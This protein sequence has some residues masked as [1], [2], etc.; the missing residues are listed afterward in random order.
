MWWTL[1][2]TGCWLASEPAATNPIAPPAYTNPVP[3][4]P[5]ERDAPAH[6]DPAP[7][8]RFRVDAAAHPDAVCNDGTTPVFY[9]RPGHGEGTEK[10]IVWMK[11]GGSCFDENSC[12]RRE[13]ARRSAK[14]WMRKEK[15]VLGPDDDGE[16]DGEGRAGGILDPRAATN[17]DFHNFNHAYLVYCSSDN[18][19]G[20]R[21]ASDATWGMHFQGSRIIDAMVDALSDPDV[22]GDNPLKSAELLVLA[23]SSA[24]AIGMRNNIDRLADELGPVRVIGISD[25]GVAPKPLPEDIELN[26]ALFKQKLALWAPRL[27]TS[28][29]EAEADDSLCLWPTRT[30]QRGHVKTPILM[31]QDQFDP[32]SMRRYDPKTQR[33]LIAKLASD[34][35]EIGRSQDAAFVPATRNHILLTNEK[36]FSTE[37][38]GVSMAEVSANWVFDREGPTHLIADPPDEAPGAGDDRERRDRGKKGRGGRK[39][40]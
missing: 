9:F 3:D 38:D 13:P 19:A 17:P 2:L 24:G 21:A 10:W 15:A 26:H 31:H 36:F 20:A 16:A 12:T 22:V 35:R 1:A 40:R 7:L 18:W 11:G 28:C 5:D 27:D 29:A 32:S 30:I 33:D 34:V 4:A 37:V 23:G 25:A 39:G 8:Q 6:G 14:P